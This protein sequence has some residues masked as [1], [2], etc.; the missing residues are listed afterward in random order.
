MN[1]AHERSDGSGPQAELLLAAMETKNEGKRTAPDARDALL[2]VAETVFADHGFVAASTRMIARAAQV[3][4]GNLH[5]YFGNKEGLYLEVFRRRGVPL[6][7][8]R[9]R[10][11]ARLQAAAGGKP[12]DI[13]ALLKAF[14]Q[15]FLFAGSQPDGEAFSQLHCRLATE[16]RAL[17]LKVRSVIYDDSTQ[18]YVRAFSAALPHIP[19][20]VLYWRLHFVIGAYTYTLMR[21]GRLEFISGGQC[22]SS[23][24][25]TAF[26]QMMPFLVA[27]L[28]APPPPETR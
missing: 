11:L 18:A 24:V 22:Q 27:G 2:T 20:T 12:L 10:Q 1:V 6:V 23:D 26:A 4:L 17:A 5:Y 9:M 15:P 25:D 21:S 3:N 14:V 8:E 7:E 19:D 28:T 13:E 16:P